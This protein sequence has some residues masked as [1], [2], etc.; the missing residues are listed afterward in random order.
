MSVAAHL[1]HHASRLAHAKRPEEGTFSYLELL[2]GARDGWQTMTETMGGGLDEA[3]MPHATKAVPVQEMIALATVIYEALLDVNEQAG[4]SAYWSDES[5]MQHELVWGAHGA[6]HGF[7]DGREPDL[8]SADQAWQAAGRAIRAAV[9]AA[10]QTRHGN[11]ETAK[12]VMSEA[13]HAI[14][15]I[16]GTITYMQRAL[17][18]AA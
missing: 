3:R 14:A 16:A 12:Y 8:Q 17:V 4:W 7:G 18:T 9:A 11:T 13:A 2:L 5:V 15:G 10:V 1:V 6:V